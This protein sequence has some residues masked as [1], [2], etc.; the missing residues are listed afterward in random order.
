MQVK[1]GSQEECEPAVVEE[2]C[3]HQP[4]EKDDR[5]EVM[6]WPCGNTQICRNWLIYKRASK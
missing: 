4:K 2:S 5:T 3:Q 1:N 6:P